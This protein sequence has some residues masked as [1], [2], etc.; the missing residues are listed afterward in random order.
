MAKTENIGEPLNVGTRKTKE[1]ECP[2]LYSEHLSSIF[3]KH[4]RVSRVAFVKYFIFD[5]QIIKKM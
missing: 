1:N 2:Y 4:A 5:E 3:L